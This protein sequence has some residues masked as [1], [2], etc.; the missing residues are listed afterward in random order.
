[1]A[2]LQTVQ[3]KQIRWVMPSYE[4]PYIGGNI[5]K[6]SELILTLNEDTSTMA[7]MYV[8]QFPDG[9]KCWIDKSDDEY[10]IDSIDW[11]AEITFPD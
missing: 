5:I 7:L 9:R 3:L 6:S 11:W 2:E 10:D 1:M 4:L 8:R